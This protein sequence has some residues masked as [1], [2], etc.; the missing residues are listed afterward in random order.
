M[1]GA[2]VREGLHF[3]DRDPPGREKRGQRDR[4]QSEWDQGQGSLC[5]RDCSP[6]HSTKTECRVLGR[7]RLDF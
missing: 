4:S 5:V 6:E 1:N 3:W 7:M 2:G